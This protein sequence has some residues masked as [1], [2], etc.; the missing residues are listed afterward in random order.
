MM[1]ALVTTRQS[2]QMNAFSNDKRCSAMGNEGAMTAPKAISATVIMSE[3]NE[4]T[5]EVMKHET[6]L[7][8]H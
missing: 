7:R 1:E 2:T 5:M 3:C 8:H 6:K 4:M